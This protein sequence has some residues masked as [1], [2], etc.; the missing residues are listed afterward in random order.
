VLENLTGFH[1]VKKFLPRPHPPQIVW[2][3]SVHYRIY[4]S[5]PLV[6]ILSQ[7]ILV[8]ALPAYLRFVLISYQSSKHRNWQVW[9][10][11]WKALSYGEERLWRLL[12][13]WSSKTLCNVGTPPP[14]RTASCSRRGATSWSP[15]RLNVYCH[16]SIGDWQQE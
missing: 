9:L 4:K 1:I 3:L 14:N 16:S 10:A 11:F 12:P 7:R 8:D 2:N 5:P 13:S 15:P 6:P